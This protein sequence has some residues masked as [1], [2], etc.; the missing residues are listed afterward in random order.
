MARHVFYSFHYIP[1]NWRAGQIR[2]IGVIEG[3]KPVSDNDWETITKGGD[4]KIKEWISQ[5]QDGKSCTIVLIGENTAGR[6]WITYEI[7]KSWNDGKGVLGIHIHNLL[8][9]YQNQANIGSNPFTHVTLGDGKNLSTVVHAYNP[10]YSSSKDVYA[11]IANNIES[12]VEEAI[13]IRSN[14]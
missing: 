1:D 3:N 13:N 14:Y 12:W 5:Q 9:R 8:D 6:K 4:D 7:V 2:N 10:P 11:Y